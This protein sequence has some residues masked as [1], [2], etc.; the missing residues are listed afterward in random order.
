MKFRGLIVAAVLLAALTGTLYWSNHHKPAE[1]TQPAADLPPKILSLPEA[2][3]TGISIQKK[4]SPEVALTKTGSDWQITTPQSLPA[5]QSAVSGVVS[6]LAS[7][8]SQRLVEDKAT[9]LQPYGLSEATLAV[10]AT[11]KNGKSQK[12]LVGDATPA[13]NGVYA[14]LEGDPR[15]FT[16]ASFNKTSL[17]KSLND[18]R[19]KRL[20]TAEPDK[21]SRVELVKGSENIEFGRDK[22]QWQIL[23]PKPM[24]ADGSKVDDLV[25]S[26]TEAKMDLGANDDPR[27]DAAAFAAGKP[28]AS[29]KITTEAGTQ[30]LQIRKDKDDYYGKTSVV[31]G[32]FKIP[33]S[34]GT[35]LNKKLDDFRNK[36]LFDFGFSDPDK[37]ELHN[38]AK[39]YFLTRGGADWWSADSKKLDA[40]SV[41]SLVADLRDLQAS[42]FVDSGFGAPAITI[43]VSSSGGKKIEK[44][45]ISKTADGKGYI[46]K[47]ENEPALYALDE[48]PVSDLLKAADQVKPAAPPDKAK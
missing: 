15:V 9:N 3:I 31:A 28:F 20:I 35:D 22:D 11:E 23:R 29:A 7:L 26:L 21:I 37:I 36:K 42:K 48:S 44:V 6:T 40:D 4:D 8:D 27:K 18:L 19:D 25:R 5:D 43:S 10:T 13:G 47:R 12:L 1:S 46:A 39:A 30:E 16:I 32:V 24:R 45:V 38:G 17:D 2:D 14:K 41:D 33:A 34:L